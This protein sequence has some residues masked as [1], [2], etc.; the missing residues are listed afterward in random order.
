MRAKNTL[1]DTIY[2]KLKVQN[3]FAIILAIRTMKLYVRVTQTYIAT[4][5]G[6]TH[7]LSSFK[8]TINQISVNKM[9]YNINAGL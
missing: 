4:P 5:T 3:S 2:L 9:S 1:A 7:V 8:Y 6:Y